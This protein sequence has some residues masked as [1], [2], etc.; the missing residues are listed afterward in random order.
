MNTKLFETI[1]TLENEIL[2]DLGDITSIPAISP[3]SGGHGEYKKAQIIIKRMKELG[4]DE[5]EIYNSPDETADNGIRPNLI[6]KI[7]G[8]SDQKL[9]LISHIDVVP[10]GDIELWDTDPF[11]AEI[12]DGKIYGRGVNDNGQEMLASI[13]ASYALMKCGITPEYEVNLCFVSDEEVGSKHGIQYLLSQ[14]LFN[15]NDLVIVPD[16]GT[17]KGNFIEIAEKSIFWI[18]FELKGKQVHASMPQCGINSCRYANEFSSSLDKALHDAFPDENKIYIPPY[19]TFEPTKRNAN[20]NNVNTVPGKEVFC[21][22]CRVLPNIKT[23]EI[24]KV[25]NA[26]IK[27]IERK[28]GIEITYKY[29]QKETASKETEIDSPVVNILKKA[30]EQIIGEKITIGGVGGG[31]C[32][33]YF[34]NDEIPAV[35]WAQEADVAHEPNEYAEIKHIINE[36]KVFSLIM[37]N[38][39]I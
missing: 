20:V 21:F 22:D 15:K 35:V 32:A 39:E 8:K 27:K 4:F 3:L 9:W 11:K 26:E 2:K 7:K 19:S 5:P 30:V 31:T 36:T 1:E 16:G 12:K 33:A 28:T 37:T 10:I 6:Y 17:P 29:L 38:K 13:Y 14:K 34:R 23:E 24:E 25:I 18:E